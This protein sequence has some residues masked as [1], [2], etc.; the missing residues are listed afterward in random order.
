MKKIVVDCSKA[1]PGTPVE[2]MSVDM[3]LEEE[4]NW[5]QESADNEPGIGVAWLAKEAER[6]RQHREQAK[7]ML[8]IQGDPQSIVVRMLIQGMLTENNL[9]RRQLGLPVQ[10]FDE[11]LDMIQRDER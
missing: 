9:L 10:T 6:R 7:A 5:K 1:V 2:G 8:N 4:A 3:T 11:F